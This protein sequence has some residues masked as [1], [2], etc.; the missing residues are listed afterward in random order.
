MM[1]LCQN[2]R[3][4]NVFYMLFVPGLSAEGLQQMILL[5]SAKKVQEYLGSYVRYA[6]K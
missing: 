1:M 3:N 4:S 2:L 5:C 6:E